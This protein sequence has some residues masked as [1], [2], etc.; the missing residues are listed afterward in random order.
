[1]KH[2]KTTKVYTENVSDLSIRLP[3]KSGDNAAA[4]WYT[5]SFDINQNIKR[6]KRLKG[7]QKFLI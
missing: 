1:M 6:W 7:V 5:F 2:R 4:C 3:E